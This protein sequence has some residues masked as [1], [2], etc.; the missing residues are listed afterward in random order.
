MTAEEYFTQDKKEKLQNYSDYHSGFIDEDFIIELMKEYA[1]AYHQEKGKDDFK[2]LL[3]W[4]SNEIKFKIP[5][6]EIKE[7][8]DDFNYYKFISE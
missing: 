4:M 7:I 2:E 5:K 1:E 8:L 3:E 6:D